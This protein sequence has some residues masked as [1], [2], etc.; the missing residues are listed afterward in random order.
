MWEYSQ[1]LFQVEEFGDK[2]MNELQRKKKKN[3]AVKQ[4]IKDIL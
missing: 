1:G 2:K 3:Q 4:A